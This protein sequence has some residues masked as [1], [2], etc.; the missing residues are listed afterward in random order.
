MTA[1]KLCNDPRQAVP[2]MLEGAVALN[3]DAV[4]LDAIDEV[5]TE[6]QCSL[7]G[8][9]V[10]GS[11]HRVP[12]CWIALCRGLELYSMHTTTQARWQ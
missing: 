5:L 1:D 9:P 10:G 6:F 4:M 2:E 3:P 11:M 7:R 8:R 12:D